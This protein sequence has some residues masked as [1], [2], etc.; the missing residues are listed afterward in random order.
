MGLSL[1][2]VIP[3]LPVQFLPGEVVQLNDPGIWPVCGR[4]DPPGFF[5]VFNL[6]DHPGFMLPVFASPVGIGKEM[7]PGGQEYLDR[8]NT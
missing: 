7:R 6:H 4:D 2:V 1:A 8:L 5:L 3:H